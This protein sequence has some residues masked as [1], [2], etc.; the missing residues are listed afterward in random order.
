M[1]NLL[2][3]KDV[4]L[5]QDIIS[6]L[7]KQ[8]LEAFE[9]SERGTIYMQVNGFNV[10]YARLSFVSQIVF[11]SLW[12]LG[13]SM[14]CLVTTQQINRKY[15]TKKVKQVVETIV[16]RHRTYVALLG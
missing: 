8:G 5:V 3:D 2:S 15:S 1:A 16:T 10:Q 4:K 13:N 7:K 9:G 12:D 14:N 6:G 11:E